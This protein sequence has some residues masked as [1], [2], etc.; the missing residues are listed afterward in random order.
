MNEFD[1]DKCRR[2]LHSNTPVIAGWLQE[3]AI[4]FLVQDASAEAVRL[5]EEAVIDC[6]DDDRGDAVFSALVRLA[7]AGNTPA[8]E[9]LCRLVVH[10]A[11]APALREVAVRGY[12]PHE[13]RQRAVFY[14]LL[15][16]WK[17]YDALDFDRHLLR[18]A[19]RSADPIL[20]NRLA[21]QARRE[22]RVEWVDVAAGGKQGK[23]LA[24]MTD[25]EWRAALTVLVR[26]E[27]WSDLWRL[28][29][30]AP[31]R[32]CAAILRLCPV[33]KVT[34]PDRHGLKDLFKLAESW[35]PDD[36]AQSYYHRTTLFG[37]EHEIRCLAI[38][39][40]DRILASGSADRTIRLW[41]L[42]TGRPLAT[43][44]GHRDWVN[45][46]NFVADRNLLV[47]AGRDGR[48]FSWRVPSGLRRR[49]LR[50]RRRP[51]LCMSLWDREGLA[52][53]GTADGMLFV[54]DPISGSERVSVDAHEG[55]VSCLAVDSQNQL[56]VTGGRD[57]R[58]RLWSLPEGK[59]R[60]TLTGHRH[61]AQQTVMPE[62]ESVLC[63]A[64]SPD[65]ALLASG[66]TG[67]EVLLWSL[68][69]GSLVTTIEAH[70]GHVTTLTFTPDSQLL[71]SGGADRRIRLW[72]SRDGSSV[73]T[74]TDHFGEINALLASPTGD[75]LVSSAGGGLGIDRSVRLWTLPEGTPVAALGGH[76]RAVVSLA[77]NSTGTVLCTGGGDGNIG[78][79]TAEVHRLANQPIS[80]STLEDLAWL[81]HTL[82]SAQLAKAER[83]AMEF[84]AALMRWRR[85]SDIL[86][87][88]SAPR[89]I[90]IGAFDIEIEG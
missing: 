7:E 85:R 74:L 9:A 28:A 79:W 39:S 31:P 2:N 82:E 61:R 36:F 73:T 60:K 11:H 70:V 81:D 21:T 18:E 77:F 78:I 44:T 33:S 42:E 59:L 88:E 24:Q 22:G 38:D 51:F 27:C 75:L 4:Q 20:R 15:G 83:A 72:H 54:W 6:V 47:S 52:V 50:R 10:Q 66:G 35:P 64:I 84:M 17:E 69:G 57:C 55:A 13:E 68:P 30:D 80:Q 14:F 37:H 67:G 40:S 19:Y 29:L 71:V 26:K 1:L 89:V 23:H 5:L 58:I 90:E 76:D 12:L 41:N 3:R 49:R 48:L 63:L 8:R 16:R 25:V 87:E 56:C 65:G 86:V 46:V 34:D 45:A 43:C 53:C 62:P 32:W